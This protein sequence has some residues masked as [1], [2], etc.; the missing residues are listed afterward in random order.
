MPD[1]RTD[2]ITKVESLQNIL[3]AFATGTGGIDDHRYQALRKELLFTPDVKGKLPAFLHSCRD[4]GQFWSFIKGNFGTYAERRGYIWKEFRP[5]LDLLETGALCDPAEQPISESLKQ[6]DEGTVH[7]VW[8]KALERRTKDPEGAITA[9]RTLLES[10]CKH[11]LDDCGIPYKEE[12]DLPGL[13]KMV[14]KELNIAPSQHSAE[15]FK[16]ILGGCTSVVE[17]LGAM[18]NRLSDAHGKGRKPVKP[19][20]RHAELAVNLAG[21]M[22]TFLVQT[23][24]ARGQP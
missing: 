5:V 22:A 11:I 7:A 24:N 21:T 10:V 16:Q 8:T 23:R 17:G 13:Y 19:S 9:A 4:L 15:V 18:R 20:A 1:L 6:F 2:L 3:V 12:S 14:S